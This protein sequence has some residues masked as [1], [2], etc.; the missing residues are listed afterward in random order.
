MKGLIGKVERL[1]WGR[2]GSIE[3]MVDDVRRA[4]ANTGNVILTRGYPPSANAAWSRCELGRREEGSRLHLKVM[5]GCG[6]SHCRIRCIWLSRGKSMRIGTAVGG[7]D[8][9]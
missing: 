2:S 7:S 6:V 3:M 5:N 9:Q 4:A 8:W 1:A